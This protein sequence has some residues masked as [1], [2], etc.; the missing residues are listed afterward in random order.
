MESGLRSL[1]FH[2]LTMT[3]SK[4][5]GLELR[6]FYWIAINITSKSSFS[7][8]KGLTSESLRSVISGDDDDDGGKENSGSSH[9]GSLLDITSAVLTVLHILIHLVSPPCE[10][11]TIFASQMVRLWHTEK[12]SNCPRVY[13]R[14]EYLFQRYE[15]SKIRICVKAFCE[16]KALYKWQQSEEPTTDELN[17]LSLFKILIHDI[18]KVN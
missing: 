9:Y 14:K 8:S 12:L 6:F 17:L 13:G 15:N 5:P 7:F 16:C 3:F 18:F 2:F 1:S 4:T 10:V 11:G